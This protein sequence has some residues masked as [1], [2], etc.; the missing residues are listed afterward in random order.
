[1]T[2]ITIEIPD[3]LTTQKTELEL[4]LGA[5]AEDEAKLASQRT[6]IQDALRSID[7]AVAVLTGQPLPAAK[8]VAATG[9]K[10]MSP[11]ARHRIAE[12]LRRSAQ[13]RAA[14]KAAEMAALVPAKAPEE[15]V[16]A[17]PAEPLNEPAPARRRARNR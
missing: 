13:A 7:T 1:L 16:P 14:K 9:R 2:P 3:S 11:E 5:I 6:E 12:G 15:P 8:S 17:L 10:P 4:R